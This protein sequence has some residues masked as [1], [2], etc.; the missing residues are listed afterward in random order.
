[1]S[2]SDIPLPDGGHSSLRQN[3]HQMGLPESIARNLLDRGESMGINKT[4]LSAV[5]EFRVRYFIVAWL[6]VPLND[7]FSAIYQI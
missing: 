4:I 5:S 6:D 1:M 3:S 7:P 2:A